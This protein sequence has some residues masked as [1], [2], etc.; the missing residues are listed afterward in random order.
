MRTEEQ[1]P[2]AIEEEISRGLLMWFG[3]GFGMKDS[4]NLFYSPT[5]TKAIAAAKA[6][7]ERTGGTLKLPIAYMRLTDLTRDGVVGFNPRSLLRR[8]LYAVT[9]SDDQEYV[10]KLHLARVDLTY[11]VV[12]LVEDHRSMLRYCSNWMVLGQ[13][14]KLNFTV[15][16]YGTDID[17][18]CRLSPSI[19]IPERETSVDEQL[20]VYEVRASIVVEGYMTSQH[21]DHDSDVSLVRKMAVGFRPVV[22]V[23]D[24]RN[25]DADGPVT[26]EPASSVLNKS[27]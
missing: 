14:N 7:R 9:D 26:L 17:I 1:R 12:Y 3:D 15:S 13:E 11:E 21:A 20:N 25:L 10:R 2:A 23:D 27:I 4:E 22:S 6:V 19:S 18:A 5:T 8:G 16:F 24:P